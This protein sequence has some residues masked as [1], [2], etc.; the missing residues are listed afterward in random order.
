L[1][2]SASRFGA[3]KCVTFSVRVDIGR[4]IVCSF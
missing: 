2:V 4:N 3:L 1:S